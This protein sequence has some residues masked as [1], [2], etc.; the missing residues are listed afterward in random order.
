MI[1]KK[2][3]DAIND[4]IKNEFYSAYLYLAMA[5]HCEASNLPGF[6]Q[7]LKVQSHEEWTHGMKFF[8]FLNDRGGRV[9]LHAISQ[10]P[11]TYKT[12]LGIFE[13]VL[14]HEQKVTACINKLYELALQERDYPTQAM[15]QWFITE[16]VEEEKNATQIVEQLK[17][18]PEKGGALLF[19]D[20]HIGK[21]GKE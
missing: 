17:M 20:R 8:E 10:P 16:Q 18:I 14:E 7:W 6:A 13:H 15:L 2:L 3:Q 19:I 4:Q 1:S 12:V 5:A 11:A 9:T 21:R